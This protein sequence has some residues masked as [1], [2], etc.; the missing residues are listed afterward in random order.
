MLALAV[1]VAMPIALLAH[2]TGNKVTGTV[3]G[4]HAA[5]NHI[6]VKSG[7]GHLVGIKVNDATKFTKGGRA[8]TFADLKEGSR[9]VV[10]TTGTGDERTA[11][12]VRM[13][14]KQTAT[15]QPAAPQH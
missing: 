4:V 12:L 7:D 8:V 15:A 9:V 13:S 3:T 14:T 1:S 6:E 11:T 2:G 5:M 10:T